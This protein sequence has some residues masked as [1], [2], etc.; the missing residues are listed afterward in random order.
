MDLHLSV[1][2]HFV[3]LILWLTACHNLPLKKRGGLEDEIANK[4]AKKPTS[5]W[6]T[7]CYLYKLQW[8]GRLHNCSKGTSGT[9]F[10]QSWQPHPPTPIDVDTLGQSGFLLRVGCQQNSPTEKEVIASE[11]WMVI[12]WSKRRGTSRRTSRT[13]WRALYLRYARCIR[14]FSVQLLCPKTFRCIVL[15]LV[16]RGYSFPLILDGT[17]GAI[18]HAI[19]NVNT[20]LGVLFCVVSFLGIM[21]SG[22]S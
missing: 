21:Q 22:Q 11:I 3:W 16:L 20:Q 7:S 5:V 13:W 1:F 4:G 9:Q 18:T 8:T 19:S 6:E 14:S 12:S 17:E 2:Q 10:V 15:V